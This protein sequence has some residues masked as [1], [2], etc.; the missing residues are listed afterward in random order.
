MLDE[1]GVNLHK[2]RHCRLTTP[3]VLTLTRIDNL[4]RFPDLVHQANPA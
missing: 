2:T 3:E 4:S 1:E